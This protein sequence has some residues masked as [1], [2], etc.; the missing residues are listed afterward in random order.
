MKKEIILVTG[1]GK[2]GTH[3][4]SRLLDSQPSLAVYPHDFHFLGAVKQNKYLPEIKEF[5][6]KN[7]LADASG[8]QIMPQ[9]END[10]IRYDWTDYEFKGKFNKKLFIEK[11]NSI[12]AKDVEDLFFKFSEIYFNCWGMD[13]K[14][15]IPVLKMV[16]DVR[17]NYQVL[18]EHFKDCKVLIVRRNPKQILA[19]RKRSNK[20]YYRGITEALVN[21][22]G[23]RKEVS[24]N[25]P[26][27]MLVEYGRL[28]KQDVTHFQDICNFLDIPAPEKFPVPTIMGQPWSGDT[29]KRIG[30]E[31]TSQEYKSIL[32]PGEKIF[33]TIGY[34]KPVS[35]IISQIMKSRR[36]IG[37]RS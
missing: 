22:A 35:S 20:L 25:S 13:T 26:R 31:D 24:L 2:S 29:N 28:S 15:K 16:N 18:Q 10:Y 27:A 11:L 37:A 7:V 6:F 8:Y 12:D 32:T 3:F 23:F 33:V 17:E 19:S 1:P 4:A 34:T 9:G 30:V 5:L 21:G 14:G 36:K